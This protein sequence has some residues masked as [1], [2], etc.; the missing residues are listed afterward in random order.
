MCRMIFSSWKEP[1]FV[2]SGIGFLLVCTVQQEQTEVG[3]ADG[4][5]WSD[6]LQGKLVCETLRL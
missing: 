5:M 1:I 2:I 4:G 6:I 3:C